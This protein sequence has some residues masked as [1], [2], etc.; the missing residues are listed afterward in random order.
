MED[1]TKEVIDQSTDDSEAPNVKPR[2]ILGGFRYAVNGILDVFR[3]QKHMRFHF[4]MV[5]LVLLVALL[6]NLEKRDMLVLLFTISLVL[7]CE[8]FN[9]AI[10]AVVDI[11][12]PTYHP[13]AKFAK[14]AAAGAVLISA[15]T[16]V[17]VGVILSAEYFDL[18]NFGGPVVGERPGPLMRV[19]LTGVI[20]LVLITI[21]KVLGTKGKLLRGGIVSGHTA[22]GFFLAAS[23]LYISKNN[24]A[25]MLGVVLALLIA[26][27]RVE[28]KIHSLQEVIIGA[29]LAMLVT[30][31]VY[32]FAPG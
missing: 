10:E 7:V 5:F 8:M 24:L 1:L 4:V 12:A 21:I 28:A 6:F 20:L 15:V 16:A 18:G 23:I 22:A 2:G 32:W 11:I 14:D 13:L 30:A 25:A 3:T 9:S 26:Q 29:V 27:S 19:F 31:V 17:V